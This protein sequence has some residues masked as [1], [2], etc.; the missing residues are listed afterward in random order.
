M[1][2]KVSKHVER[3]HRYLPFSPSHDQIYEEYQRSEDSLN[4]ATR[5]L[6]YIS[7]VI[8]RNARLIVLTGDAGHGKTHICRRLIEK[9][10]GHEEEDAREA[11]N[12]QCDG[13]ARIPHRSD[14]TVAGL[15]IVKDFSELGVE[16]AAR[17]VEATDMASDVVTV[18]C[19]NE[20]RLRA[21]LESDFA[22]PRCRTLLSAFVQSFDSGL[23]SA[24]E[25]THII[26]LNYQSV[27]S[28]S[29][30]KTNL[31]GSAL[32]QWLDRRRWR[33]C[34][35]CDSASGCPIYRNRNLLAEKGQPEQRRGRLADLFATAERLG[36]VVTIRELLMSIAYIVTG[37][38]RCKD[39]HEKRGKRPKGW[40]PQ[41]AFYNLL[42]EP[43][44]GLPADGLVRI[45]VMRHLARLDPGAHASRLVDE[46]LINR[47]GVFAEGEIDIIFRYGT[48]G[49]TKLID[50]SNGIDEIIVGNPAS[51]RERQR[52]SSFVESVVR[53]LRRRAFFDDVS[54]FGSVMSRLG[55][56]HGDDFLRIVR[57]DLTPP[58]TTELKTR[59][60]AGLHTIQGLQLGIRETHLHLVDPALGQSTSHAAILARKIAAKA[61]RLIPL[62]ATWSIPREA[63]NRA[64]SSA[65]D[66]LDRQ[67]VLEIEG[68]DAQL[69]L[70]LMMF[71]CV[72][73]AAGGFVSARFFDHEL[74]KIR[75]FLGRLAEEKSG[76]E[77]DITL[78]LHGR[79]HSVSIDGDVIQVSGGQ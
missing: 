45:P 15:R 5:A 37:G 9:H 26:N 7:D 65:V 2:D 48:G 11:I 8:N 29:A 47:Q 23:A 58:E 49:Q 62:S 63:H 40:Q 67:V 3:L 1:A 79:M 25:T 55:F 44:S 68:S 17:Y 36:A 28:A 32:E 20:G 69:S 42:F 38:L 75:T 53:S 19:A 66:W 34:K 72:V 41:Y 39:V 27:A 18:I 22:G 30:E 77:D 6:D 35:E 56:E 54:G 51:R 76:G 13:Q 24:D 61:L 59:V 46:H 71:D 50:A 31:T 43:P 74:R 14:S 60:M 4:L 64:M 10:L 16:N 21:V 33:I 73:R 12:T 78:V 57:Q 70:D 52:E